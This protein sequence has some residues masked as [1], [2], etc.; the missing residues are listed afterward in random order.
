MRDITALGYLAIFL[1]AVSLTLVLVP[2]ALRVALRRQ[3]LDR[4]GGHKGHAAP[5]PY[6]GGAAIAIAFCIS[7][8][9]ATLVRPPDGGLRELAVVLVLTVVVSLVGLADDLRGLGVTARLV[10]VGGAGFVLA[11]VGVRVSLPLPDLVNVGIT[12]VWVVGITHAFN[13][14]DNMDG[15]SAG[16]AAIGAATFGLISALQGQFLVA[17]LSVALAASAVT[18][19]VHNFHPARIYMGD[20]GSLFLGFLLAVLGIKVTVPIDPVIAAFVPI[21]ALGVAILDTTLV[22]VD[23]VRRGVSPFTG[24]RDHVSHRLVRLG[25]PVRAAVVLV[26]AVAVG[27]GW[28]AV[29]MSRLEDLVTA[30][31]LLGFALVVLAALGVVLGRVDPGPQPSLA[32]GGADGPPAPDAASSTDRDLRRTD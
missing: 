15:L 29:V 25:L 26:Y 30:Q 16:V 9:A 20:A 32:E 28:L 12:V 8:L 14:L 13:L 10:A 21:L 1:G 24:G 6:L 11:I 3:L 2:V 31:L 5:V 19:L 7:V 18:F 17:A 4:P 27:L 22:T 23:R